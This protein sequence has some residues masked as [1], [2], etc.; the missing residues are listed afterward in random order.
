MLVPALP[1]ARTV[2]LV[3]QLCRRH[4]AAV[5]GAAVVNTHDDILHRTLVLFDYY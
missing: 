5:A 1:A 4:G 2:A 3:R